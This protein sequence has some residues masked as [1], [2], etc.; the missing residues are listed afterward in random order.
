MAEAIIEKGLETIGSAIYEEGVKKGGKAYVDFF[1]P[2][3]IM[4]P[5][6]KKIG[7]KDKEG[8]DKFIQNL[9]K[10]TEHI[11]NPRTGHYTK[12]NRFA[13]SMVTLKNV[14]YSD[15]DF[16][17]KYISLLDEEAKKTGSEI[18]DM[19]FYEIK[20]LIKKDVNIQKKIL[21][22]INQRTKYDLKLKQDNNLMNNGINEQ[23]INPIPA[24]VKKPTRTPLW[25]PQYK[26]GGQDILRLTDTEKLEELKNFTLFD[27]VN[28]LLEGDRDNLLAIQNDIRQKLRFYNTY[29]PPKPERE[30]PPIPRYVEQWQRPMMATYPVPYPFKLD[31]TGNQEANK[32][33]NNFAD[34]DKTTLNSDEDVIKRSNL[35]PDVMQILNAK[36]LKKKSIFNLTDEELIMNYRR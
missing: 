36:E 7:L 26:L 18:K 22:L 27:L 30:L 6:Y 10:A 17:N 25:A 31:Q 28:P 29:Q 24:N 3:S 34:Q 15:K 20:E 11:L 35:D 1:K 9:D 14:L 8:Y 2:Q 12:A 16:M 4:D 19:E 5:I 21:E 32:Y 33:Y 23:P 13:G